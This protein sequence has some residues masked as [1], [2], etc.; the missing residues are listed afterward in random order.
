MP[1]ENLIVDAR[2]GRVLTETLGLRDLE[3]RAQ[4]AYIGYDHERRAA[5]FIDDCGRVLETVQE[6][7]ARPNVLGPLSVI[8]RA[9]KATN[10]LLPPPLRFGPLGRLDCACPIAPRRLKAQ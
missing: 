1:G 9:P 8:S 4:R 7:E 6:A 10:C 2:S 5:V 3:G